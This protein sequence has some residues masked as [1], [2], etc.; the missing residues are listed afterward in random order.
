MAREQHHAGLHFVKFQH[1]EDLSYY[2]EVV[3]QQRGKDKERH[4]QIES[5][6][7]EEE[8]QRQKNE[9]IGIF[10]S[11]KYKKVRASRMSY[12]RPSILNDS[13]S[14]KHSTEPGTKQLIDSWVAGDIASRV[15]FNMFRIAYQKKKS[16]RGA[17]DSVNSILYDDAMFNS[18]DFKP[19]T[20]LHGRDIIVL[21]LLAEALS[22]DVYELMRPVNENE[23]RQFIYLILELLYCWDID[24]SDDG[25]WTTLEYTDF[26]HTLGM[27]T[28][29][30]PFWEFPRNSLEIEKCLY[31]DGSCEYGIS[32][33]VGGTASRILPE[34]RY[35]C[36]GA[37][38]Y[39]EETGFLK[40]YTEKILKENKC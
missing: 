30:P 21:S 22:C 9:Q 12:Y 32:Y 36:R 2:D 24:Y 8:E 18:V 38:I 31:K 37:Y 17:I 7:R 6:L 19:D 26:E 15:Y 5:R 28:Q 35:L 10:T 3:S 23:V 1:K 14:G 16:L 39:Y 11:E 25:S 40:E 13:L 33:Y 4:D 27:S 20:F 29:T 34:D